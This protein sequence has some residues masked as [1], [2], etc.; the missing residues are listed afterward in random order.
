MLLPF[1]GY[2]YSVTH[3]TA[4]KV[5]KQFSRDTAFIYLAMLLKLLF[6]FISLK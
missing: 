1:Q 5:K 2:T 6:S 4:K 3:G